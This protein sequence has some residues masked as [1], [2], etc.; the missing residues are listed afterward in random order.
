M[1]LWPVSG[2]SRVVRIWMTIS[3][4]DMGWGA[5]LGNVRTGPRQALLRLTVG[6]VLHIANASRTTRSPARDDRYPHAEDDPR[7]QGVRQRQGAVGAPLERPAVQLRGRAPGQ[8]PLPL[9]RVRDD[10]PA[11]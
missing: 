10:R 1:K 6:R 9:G 11:R 5:R 3:G 4:T 2:S 8:L 7:N